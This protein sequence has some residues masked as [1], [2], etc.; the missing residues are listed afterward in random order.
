MS[1]DNRVAIQNDR[2]RVDVRAKVTGAAKYTADRFLPRMIYAK[3]IRAPFGAGTVASLDLEAARAV[4]GILEVE[5]SDRRAPRYAG[6]RM[7]Y[8]V[9]ESREAIAD[10][11]EA[12]ALRF[13]P[14]RPRTNPQDLFGGVP[15]ASD[16]E[17]EKAFATPGAVIVEATYTT[18]VQTHSALETHGGVV[19]HKGES[20]IVYGSTQGIFAYLEGIAPAVGLDA[21]K[22]TVLAEYVGGGFGAKF[23]PDAEG[24]LAGRLAKKYQRPVKVMLDRKEEHLDS[25]YRPGS[26]QYMKVAASRDG[27][28]LGAR[29][30][31]ASIGGHQPGG[32]GVRNPYCYNF[33]HVNATDEDITLHVCMPRA[34]RAP[35]CP[36]GAFAVE[37]MIDELAAACGIDP[38]EF[39]KKN[40]TSDRR[41]RQYDIGAELIGWGDRKPDGAW[42]GRV[43]TGFGCGSA[44]W[45]IWP[46]QCSASATIHRTGKVEVRC[47]VQDIGTGTM[48]LVAEVAADE[49][50]LD[51]DMIEPKVGSTAYPEGPGSGGSVTARAV[52]PAVRDACAKA[53]AS[54]LEAVAYAW[55]TDSGSVKYEGGAFVARDGRKATWAEACAVLPQGGVTEQGRVRQ[56]RLG[57]GVSD[58]VQFARVDVDTETGIV[59]VRKVVAVQACGRP[60]SRL[61]VE[62]QITGGVIQGISFALFEDRRLDGRTG[63][64]LNANLEAYK[65]AGARDIPEIIPVIDATPEDT[66]VRPL[67]EPTVIP[68]AGAIANAVANA[69]GAR[70]RSLPITPQRVLEALDARKETRA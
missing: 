62:N 38:I 50:G 33:G 15:E 59:M 17:L 35:G 26:I 56:E 1:V 16:P 36:Q 12:L 44:D 13:T 27:R 66:G 47:G 48:T 31:K 32:G 5:Y 6:D 55:S 54:L 3:F 24:S 18:Q 49:L 20:A 19:D 64:M 52:A 40:E 8:I 7:G 2:P 46:T 57:T 53:R 65:I 39:R 11:M 30:H 45:G 51:R 14:G 41:R 21:S 34:M 61:P 9:G 68:T 69:T 25:G 28:I 10:A 63:A 23:G 42:P 43:K 37:S 60:V 4:K 58:T 70:V 22:V 29:I 67:G